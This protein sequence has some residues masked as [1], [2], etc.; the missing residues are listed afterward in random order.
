MKKILYLLS[1]I[2]L[3][4]SCSIYEEIYFNEDMSVK[5]QI[6]FD[7]GEWMSTFSASTLSGHNKSL[8]NDSV[9]SVAEI[10]AEYKDPVQP[11]SAEE[12]QVLND[13]RPLNLRI[14]SDT[15]ANT[16]FI[17]LYGDFANAESLNRVFRILAEHNDKT[18]KASPRIRRIYQPD[19]ASRYSWDGKT[20]KREIDPDLLRKVK[21]DTENDNGSANMFTGGKMIVKYHFPKRVTNVSNPNALLSQD[22]KTVVLEYPATDFVN[23]TEKTNV[24][25]MT[26]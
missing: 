24:E 25:I 3:S 26:E 5:Y 12:Q 15:I 21:E 2:A 22:G 1:I 7:D 13:L 10:M 18:T 20:M 9:I 16:F 11:L 19:N 4:S 17:S 14:N 23:S 6:K 8:P